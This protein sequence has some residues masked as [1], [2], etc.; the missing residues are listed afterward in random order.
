MPSLNNKDIAA[1]LS[2]TFTSFY[3]SEDGHQCYFLGAISFYIELKGDRMLLFKNVLRMYWLKFNLLSIGPSG[4]EPSILLQ[5]SPLL[6]IAVQLYMQP[7]PKVPLLQAKF[8]TKT[9]IL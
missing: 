1:L 7:F 8:G 3:D 5:N 2:Y 4:Q 6:H 9:S